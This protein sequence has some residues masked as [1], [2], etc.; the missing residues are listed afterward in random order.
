MYIHL[1]IL[2]QSEESGYYR[3]PLSECTGIYTLTISPSN[4]TF[5]PLT[6]NIPLGISPYFLPT[7]IL[8]IVRCKTRL[9]KYKGKTIESSS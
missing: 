2:Q 1:S 7:W 6:T 4:T 3:L 8:S 5:S 9:A